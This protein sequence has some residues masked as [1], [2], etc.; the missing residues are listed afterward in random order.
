MTRIVVELDEAQDRLLQRRAAEERR[1]PQDLCREAL[2]RYLVGGS[3]EESDRY[4]P[5][6]RMIGLVADGPTDA[7]IRHDLRPEDDAP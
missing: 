6:R 1:T 5:F 7:S 4:E 3:S 2:L